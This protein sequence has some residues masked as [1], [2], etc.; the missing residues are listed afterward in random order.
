MFRLFLGKFIDYHRYHCIEI[1]M[2]NRWI[3]ESQ[4]RMRSCIKTYLS[5]TFYF[6]LDKE[7]RMTER[8]KRERGKKPTILFNSLRPN[9]LLV[10]ASL[11][12][13]T[14]LE[15]GVFRYIQS[16]SYLTNCAED[17]IY[18]HACARTRLLF[19]SWE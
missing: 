10:L 8:A 15:N 17:V 5:C 6:S 4:S 3:L 13:I 11:Q 18:R 16:K 9:F 2:Y 1:K 19:L 12:C 7:K 14:Y